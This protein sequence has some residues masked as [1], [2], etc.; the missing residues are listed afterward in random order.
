MPMDDSLPLQIRYFASA[1][2]AAGCETEPLPSIHRETVAE[3][4]GRLVARHPSLAGILR[5]ARIAVGDEFRVDADE[6]P[7]GVEVLV[8][9]AASGGAPRS[10]LLERPIEAGEAEQRVG[11]DGAGGIATF[12]GIVR[13]DNLGKDVQSLE[14]TAYPP[15]ALQEMEAICAEAVTRFGLVDVA[16][17]HRT[18][19]LQIGEIAVAIATSA[20]H[21]REAFDACS[22][23]IDELKKRVPIWKKETTTDGASW[24]GSTP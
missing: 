2:D 24:L 19:L 14:Y 16:C 13:R 9:P 23:V 1:R 12:V 3:L 22:Y 6:I 20:P 18:G 5:H 10:A 4:R 21:R 17:L 8:L 7:P 11:K 15:L